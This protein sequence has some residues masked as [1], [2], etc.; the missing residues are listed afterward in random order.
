MTCDHGDLSH[1]HPASDPL[2][3][4]EFVHAAGLSLAALAGPRE[5]LAAFAQPGPVVAADQRFPYFQSTPVPY[6]NVKLQDTF[7]A[8][9]QRVVR[10]VTVAWATRHFDEAGG[11]E[12]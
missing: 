5:L 4:R 10:D 3:R 9:R 11:L 8:P 2:S 12:A 7:W 6:F 1:E